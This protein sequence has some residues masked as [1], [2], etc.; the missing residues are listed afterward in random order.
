[1]QFVL[2]H[3]PGARRLAFLRKLPLLKGLSDNA[4][5][6]VGTRVTEQVFEVRGAVN[7]SAGQASGRKG[8]AGTCPACWV[9]VHACRLCWQWGGGSMRR[10]QRPCRYRPGAQDGQALVRHG[11]TGVRFF[12]IRYG[13]VSVMRPLSDGGSSEVAI[14]RRGQFVG[15]RT[16]ITGTPCRALCPAKLAVP[17]PDD[18]LH[19]CCPCLCL[20]LPCMINLCAAASSVAP[21]LQ[22]SYGA[23]TA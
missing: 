6:A 8:L 17:S 3:A 9:L 19:A 18:V 5:L 21:V 23:Q 7:T 12:V 22:A 1:M 11:E 4:L 16:L 15:E 13:T 20:L 10:Q 2:H 14:M